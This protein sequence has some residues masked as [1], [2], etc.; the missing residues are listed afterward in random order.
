MRI[1]VTGAAGYIGTAVVRELISAGHQVVGLTR[2]E[3]GAHVLESLGAEVAC[4]VLEDLDILRSCAATSDG[5][6]H[7]AFNHD[8]SNFA[9]SLAADLRAIEAMGEALAGSGKPLVITAHANGKASEDAALSF[10]EQGVRASIVSLAPSVHGEGDKGFVPQLIRIAQERGSSAYIGDGSNRWP[11]IHRLDA[12]VLFRLA[13]ESAPAGARLDGVHD[14]GITF[15]D[16]AAAIGRHVN[17]PV[18]SIPP[19]EAQAIFGFL[20]MVASLDLARSSEGTKELLDWE[21]VQQGLLA[22]LEQGHYFTK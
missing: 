1:F 13:V 7:L 22:D 8:F 10:I 2:S 11:A 12:A 21:P 5:V 17:V 16:I 4:G 3:S 15:R 19:E 9:A 20:G 6:I 18:V 14:E